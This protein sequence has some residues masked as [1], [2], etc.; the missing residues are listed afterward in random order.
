M[1][2]V[3]WGEDWSEDHRR[4]EEITRNLME[5]AKVPTRGLMKF[6]DWKGEEMNG[7]SGDRARDEIEGS[8]KGGLERIHPVEY[9]GL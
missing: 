6:H 9:Q 4:M 2:D 5:A 7:T 8:Y 1:K 3:I